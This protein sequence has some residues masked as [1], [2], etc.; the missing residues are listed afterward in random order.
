MAAVVTLLCVCQGMEPLVILKRS[1][2]A[3]LIVGGTSALVIET[4]K[5]VDR[6]NTR[7]SR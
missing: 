2:I 4:L 7:T 1:L 6:Q 3:S 5:A